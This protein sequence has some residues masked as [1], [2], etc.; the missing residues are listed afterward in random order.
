MRSISLR[1]TG[2]SALLFA[3]V[4]AGCPTGPDTGGDTPDAGTGDETGV[5]PDKDASTTTNPDAKADSGADS[6]TPPVP[7]SRLTTLCKDGEKC[8]GAPDCA[9]KVCFNNKCAVPAPADGVKN[10]DETDV[11]CGG[12]KAP[13]CPATKACLVPSDCLSGVC[14]GKICQA[15][16][17]TDGVKNGD[18]TGV[19][20]GGAAAPKCPAGQ[21]CLSN[22]DCDNIKCDLVT[23]KC[24]PASHSDGIKNLDET[25]IDCG[26]PTPTVAR[27]APGGGCVATSDCNNTLCNGGGTCDPAT[28]VDGLK[29][30][31]ETDVDCGGGPGGTNAPACKAGL[32]CAGVDANCLSSVCNYANKCVEAPSCRVANGGDTCGASGAHESCCA[33][34]PLPASAVQI[35]KYEI[36]AGRM[37]EFIKQ[38]GNNVQAW[39]MAHPTAQIPAAL[40][41]FLPTGLDTPVQSI[42]RCNKPARDFADCDTNAANYSTV[43][44]SFG[45]HQYLG[46]NVFMGDRPCPGCG[47]GCY[48]GSGVGGNGHPTYWWDDTTQ[49]NQF[50]SAKRSI[51]FGAAA[52]S[53]LDAKSLNCTPQVLFAAF[54]A[55]DGGRLPTQA[56]LG[57]ASGAWGGAAQPWGASPD[58]HD[59]VNGAADVG[60]VTY[61]FANIQAPCAGGTPCFVVPMFNGNLAAPALNPAA[62]VLNT[63]NFNPFPSSPDPFEVRY[64]NPIPLDYAGFAGGTQDD[65]A[66]AIAEPGRM[67]NDFRFVGPNPTDGYYDVMANLIEVT[68][69]TT[70]SDDAN[71]N[72]W[73]QVSWVGGSFEGH[74]PA[75]RGGYNLSVF[76]KYGK[77]GARCAR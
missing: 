74:T 31:N 22:A 56:E 15:P 40:V 65:Q 57:G 35:D 3:V 9:S 30:G 14:T 63:T 72:G 6:A 29:N 21:G 50:G 18:E 1:T 8:D 12:S 44:Q 13:A 42:Q 39:V 28:N 25:G 41:P 7:C 2:L 60:R 47:Q 26:G 4:L 69:T 16:S 61:G 19:D 55:W 5:T 51:A 10:G 54:C 33:S 75:N 48:V 53:I 52:Q 20:C 11:D 67:R 62:M 58:F 32:A 46:N 24:L 59:T 66:W 71:H 23:K 70:G 27:C 45:V 76:T 73:P 49:T 38:V 77:Q 64:M 37:R 43:S 36:T 68:A 17:P 34:V